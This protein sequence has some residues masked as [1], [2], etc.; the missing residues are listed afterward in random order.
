MGMKFILVLAL[1]AAIFCDEMLVTREYVDFLKRRVSWEVQ[2]YES[3][4]FRGWTV[5]EAKDFLG[6]VDMER[7]ESLPEVQHQEIP[8]GLD[9]SGANCDHGPQNQGN[10][11]SCWAFAATGML[12]DRCCLH[13]SDKG[14][15]APQELVSCDKAS[16]GCQGGSLTSPV[17]YFQK[18]GGLVPNPC[19]P[20]KAQNVP[21]PNKCVDGKDFKAAHV[22]KC[23]SPTN[24]SGTSGIKSCL[25]KGPVTIG[26]SVC[27]SF[28]NYKS[29][30]Y[31][32]D[33]P[34]YV[35][36]HAVLVMGHSDSPECH[37]TV[38]NS[39]GTSWGDHG[40]FKIACTTCKLQGGAVCGQVTAQASF[41][42]KHENT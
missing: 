11:G 21:C 30:I 14:W 24:C 8:E 13:S 36:G 7:D 18:A 42:T 29:G 19:F 6:L 34:T 15:L 27:K 2:D 4:I 12:S 10:C 31:K 20:Y 5:E 22:C 1:V 26:F 3:N 25:A 39:W 40:Y 35:G 32:C 38:K 28:M 16:H 23:S 33:C 17:S 9:W 41:F 37:F